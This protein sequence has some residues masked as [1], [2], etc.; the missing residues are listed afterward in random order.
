MPLSADRDLTEAG[1]KAAA[2]AGD[3][4]NFKASGLQ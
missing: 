4:K 2:M 3:R 1:L